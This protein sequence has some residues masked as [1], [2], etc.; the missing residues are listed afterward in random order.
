MATQKVGAALA[1]VGLLT[2]VDTVQR[3]PL[4]FTVQGDDGGWY[5]YLQ[6]VASTAAG[7][8]IIYNS[9]TYLTTRLVTTVAAGPVAVAMGAILLTNF[10]WY[11]V[12]GIV[13]SANIATDASAD[14]KPLYAS[15]SAG[16]A[17]TT[18]ASAAAIFGANGQGASAS[19]VGNAYFSVNPFTM[20]SA[21]L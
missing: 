13:V 20:A 14:G 12:K 19:N 11:Q 5:T 10:G 8:F 17:T 3:N 4:G 16:R 15:S 9:A 21:T 18:P 7:D 1:S 2:D 6:G